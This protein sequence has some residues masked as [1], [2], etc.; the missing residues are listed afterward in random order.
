MPPFLPAVR[1]QS[2]AWGAILSGGEV[3]YPCR[4]VKKQDLTPNS[5][6]K[7]C[8]LDLRIFPQRK[9]FSS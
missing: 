1:W 4:H 8:H 9:G 3:S 6:S 7:V 5:P 2:V